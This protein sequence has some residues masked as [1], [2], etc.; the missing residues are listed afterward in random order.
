MNTASGHVDTIEDARARLGMWVFLA[1]EIMFFGPV[2]LAYLYGRHAWP[3]AFEA[4]SRSTDFWLGT[5]NT[6]VLLSS[7]LFVAIALLLAQRGDLRPARRSLDVVVLLGAVFLLIKGWEYRQDW[8]QGL[9]P[10][11]AGF[12]VEHAANQAAAQLFYFIYFF[13]TL[14]H[15][16]HMAIGIGLML[17]CRGKLAGPKGRNSVRRLE[18]CG[19]YWHFVDIVWIFLFPA[20]YLAGRAS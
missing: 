2:F 10:G 1:S 16:V 4:A 19:L 17:Y 8:L 9:V 11:R 7:S 3:E 14:L 12:H 13:A 18:I 15:A 5:I 20:L 6:A